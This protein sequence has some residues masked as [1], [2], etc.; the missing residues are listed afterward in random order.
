MHARIGIPVTQ[1][2]LEKLIIDGTRLLT[3]FT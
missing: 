2:M 3:N 1:E